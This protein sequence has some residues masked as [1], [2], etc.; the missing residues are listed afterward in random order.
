MRRETEDKYIELIIVVS[1]G[2]VDKYKLK[3]ATDKTSRLRPVYHRYESVHNIIDNFY[4]IVGIRVALL[5]IF[6]WDTTDHV[7]MKGKNS[8][9]ILDDFNTWRKNQ[10]RNMTLNKDQRNRWKA[11]DNAQFVVVS[12]PVEKFY[13]AAVISVNYSFSRMTLS[14]HLPLERAGRTLFA[15][16]FLLVLTKIIIRQKWA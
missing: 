13:F 2:L 6:L 7:N 12:L 8:G 11:H 9:E 14:N 3:N 4:K 16:V 15:S 10:A 1:K 5:D